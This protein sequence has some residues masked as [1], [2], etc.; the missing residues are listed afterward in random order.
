MKTFKDLKDYAIKIAEIDDDDKYDQKINALGQKTES[1]L[2]NK[3]PELY[4][5]MDGCDGDDILDCI[6]VSNTE[7]DFIKELIAY[8]YIDPVDLMEFN[9][10]EL[11][12]K[13]IKSKLY[14]DSE[15]R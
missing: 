11:I 12:D 10:E 15:N 3:Y 13:Y 4:E 14:A 8:Y 9:K 7:E 5:Y 2:S 1:F 6:D